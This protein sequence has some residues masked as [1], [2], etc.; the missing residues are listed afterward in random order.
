[1]TTERHRPNIGDPAPDVAFDTADGGVW[2]LS[3]RAG[4]TVI[5]IFHRHIH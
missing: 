2:R 3:E 5:L 1:M 4:H